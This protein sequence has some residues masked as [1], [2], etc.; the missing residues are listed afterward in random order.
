MIICGN[1]SVSFTYLILIF[2]H[3]DNSMLR[4]RIIFIVL[5]MAFA[6]DIDKTRAIGGSGIQISSLFSKK[7]KINQKTSI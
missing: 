4:P 7:E 6:R 2:R 3:F 5:R 1:S